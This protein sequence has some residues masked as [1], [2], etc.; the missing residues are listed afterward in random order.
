MSE[1]MTRLTKWAAWLAMG[2]LACAGCAENRAPRESRGPLWVPDANALPRVVVY[3]SLGNLLPVYDETPPLEKFL[4]GPNP[5]RFGAA[6]LRNPQGMALAWDRILVCDQG[7][8]DILAID[9][10][11]GRSVSWG[12]ADHRPRCPVDVTTDAEGRVY[13]AD[14]TL[15]AVLQY[16]ADERFVAELRPPGSSPE[17]FRPC[18]VLVHAGILYVGNPAA[19]RVDRFDV[20]RGTWLPPFTPSG[21]ALALMAPTGIAAGPQGDLLVADA[22]QGV[23]HRMTSEGRWLIP[24]GKPGREAGRFVRPKQVRCTASGL[25]FVSDV[26]RQSVLVFDAK[27]GFLFEVNGDV[28]AGHRFSLPMG[29]VTVRTSELPPLGRRLAEHPELASDECVIVSDSLGG[30]SLVVLGVVTRATEGR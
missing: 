27:G 10:A 18:S 2:M 26:G 14:T 7:F 8:P 3:G 5:G 6:A 17:S 15:R 21:T 22:L 13:V 1:P 4:Y 29:L 25:I 9:L 19:R 16:G 11:T 23:V 20:S 28:G 24:I 30:E 12:D